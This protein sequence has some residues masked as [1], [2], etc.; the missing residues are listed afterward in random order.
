MN[1]PGKWAF[2]AE[3]G[4]VVGLFIG[5]NIVPWFLAGLGLLVVFLNVQPAEVRSLALTESYATDDQAQ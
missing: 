2:L 3:L 1:T 4:L 5:G